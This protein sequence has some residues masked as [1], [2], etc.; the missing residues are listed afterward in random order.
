M[1]LDSERQRKLL[2]DLLTAVT[3]PGTALDEVFNLKR[4]ILQAK[5]QEEPANEK[6][7]RK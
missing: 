4:Q 1:I 2:L 7:Q 6:P 5:I 3:I